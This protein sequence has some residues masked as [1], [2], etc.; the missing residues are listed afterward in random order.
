MPIALDEDVDD[1]VEAG[2][3][4]MAALVAFHFGED[5]FRYWKG[6]RDFIY[7]GQVYKPN[8]FLDASDF[9]E[10]LGHD[11]QERRLT[12]SNVPT[13]DADD[14]VAQIEEYA[15]LGALAVVALVS[16]DPATG[17]PLGL[18]ASHAM[19]IVDVDYEKGAADAD[20]L[21]AVS[22]AILLEPWG[23]S[24]REGTGLKSSLAEQQF[25]NDPTCTGFE[26]V[27]LTSPVEMEWG[28]KSG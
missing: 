5:V 27:G 23:A 21:Q 19:E 14:A 2:V 7:D 4:R 8:R 12:F 1:A 28:Q 11:V 10:V 3:L 20:G 13:E 17:E 16:V 25:D 18:L 15:Y 26:N 22:L 6:N 24:R 9:E